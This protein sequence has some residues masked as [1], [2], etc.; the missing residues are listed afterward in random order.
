MWALGTESGASARIS[1]AVTPE[2]SLQ[3]QE[4]FLKRYLRLYEYSN[5]YIC[6]CECWCPW[7]PEEGIRFLVA[8]ATGRY[9]LP[10]MDAR[11]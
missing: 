7:R 3:P 9:E 4:F 10:N 8:G 6:V 5:T 1:R 11:N 2:P